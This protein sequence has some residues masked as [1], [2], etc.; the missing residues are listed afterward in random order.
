[1]QESFSTLKKQVIDRGLCTA[2]GTCAGVCSEQAIEMVCVEEEPEPKLTGKCNQ[3][4]FCY[5]ACPG[6]VVPLAD[7]DRW[8]FGKPSSFHEAPLGM[9]RK[10]LR[11]YATDHRLRE[12][13]SSGG[14]TSAIL[15]YALDSGV[16]DGAIIVCSNPQMPWRCSATLV[17][18]SEQTRSATRSSPEMVPVN[19]LLKHSVVEKGWRKIGI[20]GL[21][22]HI[23][24]LRKIQMKGEPPEISK[25]IKLC[26]GLFCAATY[27]FEGIKHLLV[28]FAGIEEIKEVVAMDYKGGRWP[29][30]LTVL[31]RDGKIT[32]VATKHEYTWHF[33]GPAPYKR[34][35]CLMCPDFS[36]RVADLSM[37]DVF[38]KVSD[39]PNLTAVLA[40]TDIGETILTSASSAGVISLEDH[41]PEFI[42]KSG[43]GWESKEHAGIFRTR[44]RKRFGWPTPD[45][46]YPL[47]ICPLPGKIVF[48]S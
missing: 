14:V 42:P 26:I 33:L 39:N 21:P 31:T 32:H 23:H 19:S 25:A 1:M 11:G 47:K 44:Q 27:Y 28:E 3:C 43:M 36:A 9:Y 34:D 35:R 48:P 40:R 45:F 29:G 4:G 12:S 37:G 38:Q 18:C 22:C 10:S 30:S 6:G 46:Q 2:C 17:S 13:S 20:V 16:I 8:L 7:M 5:N 24:G 41:P 15:N